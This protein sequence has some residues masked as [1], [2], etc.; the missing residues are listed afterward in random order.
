MHQLLEDQG[1]G[2]FSLRHAFIDGLYRLKRHYSVFCQ[3]R[4]QLNFHSVAHH[5]VGPA[6]LPVINITNINSY[7][8][9][10]GPNASY[11]AGHVNVSTGTNVA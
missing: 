8:Q 5:V 9:I 7:N 1:Y 2:F 4:S 3:Q 6:A 11:S 10:S